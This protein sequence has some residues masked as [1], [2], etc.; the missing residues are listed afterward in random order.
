MTVVVRLPEDV[1]ASARQT[2]AL[3]GRTAAEMVTEAWRQYLES[4]HDE[5]AAAYEEAAELWR[6][7]DSEALLEFASRSVVERAERAAEEIRE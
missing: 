5:F 2:G 6:Q 3:E 1:I 7:G 4:H